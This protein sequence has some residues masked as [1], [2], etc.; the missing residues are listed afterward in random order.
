MSEE[1][2][3]LD[4]TTVYLDPGDLPPPATKLVITQLLDASQDSPCWAWI[5]VGAFYDSQDRA[6]WSTEL[7]FANLDP[8]AGLGEERTSETEA[9]AGSEW[10]LE[11]AAAESGTEIEIE[12]GAEA[13]AEA[14]TESRTGTSSNQIACDVRLRIAHASLPIKCAG[15]VAVNTELG[16]SSPD[17]EYRSFFQLHPLRFEGFR[18]PFD[19]DIGD[20]SGFTILP[21]VHPRPAH[22]P[23]LTHPDNHHGSH[24]HDQLL[25]QHPST[26]PNP[27]AGQWVANYDPVLGRWLHG[28]VPFH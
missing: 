27:V 2:I 13:E 7:F 19:P 24:H 26:L 20:G 16:A 5:I 10:E 11:S 25:H 8:H 9:E 22:D 3:F 28:F 17:A 12:A 15:L 23:N 21:N 18:G 1:I 6:L 14:D 4:N